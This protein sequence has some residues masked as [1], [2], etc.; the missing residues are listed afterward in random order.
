MTLQHAM[1]HQLVKRPQQIGRVAAPDALRGAVDLKTVPREDVLQAVQR[2]V[3]GVFAGDHIRQQP[4][5]GHAFVDRL[6]R[7]FSQ[8]DV[9]VFGV[10]LALLAG[11]L[12]LNVLDPLEAAGDIFDLPARFLADL[13]AGFAAAGT[14]LLS[15]G[16]VV[17]LAH[18]RQVI[19]RR[20]V[21]PAAADA[22][23]CRHFRFR[24]IRRQ[25]GRIHRR[26]FHSPGEFQQH[27]RRV[28][29]LLQPVG[30]RAVVHLL[31]TQEF[32][33]DAELLNLDLPLLRLD[34]ELGDSKLI[35]LARQGL[36]LARQIDDD[37]LE[38]FRIARQGRDGGSAFHCDDRRYARSGKMFQPARF[39]CE[40]LFTRRM[41]RRSMP[42]SSIASSL[43]RN[44]T[45]F[46]S[47][48]IRGSLKTPSS[49]RLYQSA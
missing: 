31:Q 34:A 4:R 28:A 2:Q 46:W 16:Q 15:V 10:V 24:N 8:G 41:L 36:T 22:A 26:Q 1:N 13:R 11:V 47:P 27:L 23:D 18:H 9:G 29:R 32:H 12:D 45:D 25:I 5:T 43:A 37:Q 40:N 3:I 30:T 35:T 49:S 19:E 42:S 44:S 6:R 21:A 17:F 39:F 48:S 7:F 20:Q 38:R 33:F 14:D